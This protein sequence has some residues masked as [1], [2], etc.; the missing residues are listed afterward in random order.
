V[1]WENSRAVGWRGRGVLTDEQIAA[2][3]AELLGS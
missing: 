3:K 1:V 2:E